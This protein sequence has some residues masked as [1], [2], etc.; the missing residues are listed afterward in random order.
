MTIYYD[1]SAAVHAHPGLGRYAESLGRALL[2]EHGKA[3]SFFYYA[4]PAIQSLSGLDQVPRRV[5]TAGR[6]R[7]RLQVGLGQ[8]L[9]TPFDRLLP[10][11]KLYHA[12]E[13]LLMP[14]RDIPTVLTVHDLLFRLFPRYH[15]IQ[16]YIYLNLAVPIFCRRADAIIAVSEHTKGDLVKYYHVNPHKVTVIYE[17]AAPR[18]VPQPG[19]KIAAVRA[20]YGLPERY[21][22]TLCAI[23]PRKN[24]AG[25]LRA[26][27]CLCRDDPDLYWVIGGRKAW[28]YEQ[29]FAELE[30][31][32]ARDRV[33]LPG[34]IEDEDLPAAYGGA[35]AFV[36]P[37]FGEG[38]GLPLLEAM[39]CGTP[40]ISSDATSLPEVGG[41]AARYFD[42][43]DVKEMAG[44]T[45]QVLADPGLRTD[46]R[47]T[48]LA[49]AAR[50]SWPRA[51]EETWSLYQ[52]VLHAE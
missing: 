46:M 38:F 47:E 4:D 24:H 10:D 7:W 37:S 31:S 44:I 3:I 8:L 16:N 25:F 35:L 42:P 19:Q 14:L 41:N 20:R 49:Q 11:A 13:H 33:I 29:F 50:F 51:A 27:E 32:P 28:L 36:F 39:G 43:H 23:E 2:G 34:Y 1:V 12:T 26:F 52:R 18:F 30:R 40:V 48:G 6:K 22:M 21:L 5:V 9:S 17:A 45:R 15:K